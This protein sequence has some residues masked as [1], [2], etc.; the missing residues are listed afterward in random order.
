MDEVKDPVSARIQA[1]DEVG[2]GDRALGRDAGAERLDP[3]ALRDQL[4]EVGH[5]LGV[6]TYGL[7][8]ELRIESVDA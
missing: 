1:R 5:A 8:E 7:R 3:V 2:P 6:E 4:A